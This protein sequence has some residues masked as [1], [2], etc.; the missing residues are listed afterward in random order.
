MSNPIDQRIVE[1]QFDNKEFEKNIKTTEES[2]EQF[3]K[4]LNLDEAAE[5]FNKIDKA[6]RSF[7][8]V[9]IGDQVGV[10]TSGFSS[11][12]NYVLGMFER[13]KRSA[14]DFAKNIADTIT[15][16]SIKAGFQ[17]YE[18]QIGAQ[19]T[20]LMG[21]MDSQ[22]GGD[23]QKAL[24]AVNASLNELNHYADQTI[25]N[26][27]Q[28][29]QAIGKF[30]A[31]GV[32]LDDA[33][34]S[35]KGIANLAA[36]AGA[37][38][39]QANSAM[40]M[41]SQSLAQGKVSLYQWRSLENS[42][43]ANESF[44]QALMRTADAMGVVG[45]EQQKAYAQLKKGDISFR[46]SIGKGWLSSDILIATLKQYAGE[47]GEAELAA[48]GF[49]S[50]E[51]AEILKMGK[52]AQEA[53]TKVKTFTQLIDVLKEALQSG[54]T[55]SW[56]IIFGD[57]DEAKEM[58][59]G[60][61][62]YLGN[63]INNMAEKRNA[64]LK[65]WKALGGKSDII[66][67]IKALGAAT[68]TVIKIFKEAFASVLP[69]S[70]SAKESG[71]ILKNV[72]V[73]FKL[74]GQSIQKWVYRN[75]ET[76]ALVFQT[77]VSIIKS[78]IGG[79]KNLISAVRPI[80]GAFG[81]LIGAVVNFISTLFKAR[82]ESKSVEKDAKDKK[83]LLLR[84][85]EWI[86]KVID[87]ITA[88][89]GK[90]KAAIIEF[91]L[92]EKFNAI[93]EKMSFW[94]GIVK[95]AI[96][97]VL[98]R[99]KTYIQESGILA[100]VNERLKKVFNVLGA[101]IRSVA[102]KIKQ[103]LL[104]AFSKTPT[105]EFK[106]FETVKTKLKTFYDN[107]ALWVNQSNSPIAG[108]VQ[109]LWG[110]AKQLWAALKA[111]FS[112]DTSGEKG[113]IAKLKKRFAAFKE[114]FAS[115]F[116]GGKLSISGIWERIKKF[117][118]GFFTESFPKFFE[119][120]GNKLKGLSTKLG[121][122]DLLKTVKIITK[123][124]KAYALLRAIGSLKGIIKGIR[125]LGKGLGQLGES[126]KSL[127]KNG[128]TI[129]H[130]KKD[131]LGTTIL[132]IA[133]AIGILVAALYV[134]T[135][136][137]RQDLNR[138]IIS[139]SIIIAALAILAKSAK[140][141]TAGAGRAL[142][143]AGAAVLLM[144]LAIKNLSGMD[145]D[146]LV[147]G[148]AAMGALLLELAVF[149]RIAGNNPI[150]G[151][152]FVG[153]AI[154]IMLMSKSVKSFS[155]MDLKGLVKGIGSLGA[156]LL[157]VAGFARLTSGMKIPGLLLMSVSLLVMGRAVRKLGEL[158]IKTLAKG[159][160]AVD[161]MLGGFSLIFLASKG[162]SFG[163]TV[164]MLVAMAGAMFVFVKAINSI[165]GVDMTGIVPFAE[166]FAVVILAIAGV[167][168]VLSLIN[169]GAC[170]MGLANLALIIVALGGLLVGL[171]ALNN[172]KFWK[173]RNLSDRLA[174]G[175]EVLATLAEVI[176]KI[177]GSFAGGAAGEML[178][179]IGTAISNF[180]V[181]MEPGMAV[182]GTLTENTLAGAGIFTAVGAAV[183]ATGF[184]GVLAEAL[185]AVFTWSSLPN[186]G[187][188]MSGFIE[189]IGSSKGMLESFSQDTVTGA[190]NLIAACGYLFGSSV[191]ASIASWVGGSVDL[192]DLTGEDGIIEQLGS[193]LWYFTQSISG[194]STNAAD[195]DAATLA[196]RG[197]SEILN[198]V[199]REGGLWQ[200]LAGSKSN[201]LEDFA[202]HH[203]PALGK[204]IRT[205]SEEIAGF[206]KGDDMAS[207]ND[208]EAAQSCA[209]GLIDLMNALPREGGIAQAILGHKD[210]AAFVKDLPN[211]AD[212]LKTYSKEIS[213]FSQKK[214]NKYGLATDSDIEA[215]A[216][217][218]KGLVDL[219]NKLPR[220]GGLLQDWIGE[221]DL[222]AFAKELPS[223]GKSLRTYSEE[224]S[225]FT[226]ETDEKDIKNAQACAEGLVSLQKALEPT[227]GIWQHF[228]G[229]VDLTGFADDV[230]AIGKALG[231]YSDEIGDKDFSTSGDAIA[232]LESLV[233]F[234]QKTNEDKG[235]A[236][237]IKE[238]FGG[239]SKLYKM[240]VD[241]GQFGEGFRK[242]NQGIA[243]AS[244]VKTRVDDVVEALNSFFAEMTNNFVLENFGTVQ[245]NLEDLGP[246]MSTFGDGFAAFNRA[247]SGAISVE[248]NARAVRNAVY[249]LID[250]ANYAKNKKFDSE[251]LENLA[252]SLKNTYVAD[253]IWAFS[254]GQEQVNDS[255]KGLALNAAN[256]AGEKEDDWRTIGG[257]LIIGLNNGL[258]DKE[259]MLYNTAR[260]IAN[261]ITNIFK[262]VWSIKS[263]SRVF[264]D[265]GMYIDQG[266]AIGISKY[267]TDVYRTVEDTADG[268]VRTAEKMLLSVSR[269]LSEGIDATPV[270]R[271]VL[272]LSEVESGASGISGLFETTPTVRTGLF[273]DAMFRRN[274]NMLAYEG[275]RPLGSNQNRDIITEIRGLSEKFEHLSNSVSNMQMVLDSGELIGRLGTKIDRNLGIIA[276][277]RERGN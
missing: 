193:S 6:A 244:I 129:T 69:F 233:A 180:I 109:K 92:F 223:I 188:Q 262:N 47:V 74:F 261:S 202:E 60:V 267:A 28:M 229:E 27:T 42:G 141:L 85:G 107:L 269:T 135:K 71:Q 156:I 68:E 258:V 29:T 272:D 70:G 172:A 206:A 266:L 173:E 241:I 199:P 213:G 264:Q 208:I 33:T 139:L 271:P 151:L 203:V 263:P 100:K 108:I 143:G 177:I 115:W 57:L 183:F 157:A 105:G 56:Q 255:A 201:S 5:S 15:V 36:Y 178:P 40:Y 1:M 234:A 152:S 98:N 166:G 119:G 16:D 144:S 248:T 87:K 73:A 77:I 195:I 17:E 112:V 52:D 214:K 186:V 67:G 277:R 217:C 192:S 158:D 61:S 147:K 24:D 76:I 136:I 268:T 96:A 197:L 159:I 167:I 161:L 221:K 23:R 205:Y 113:F 148:I 219:A 228:F 243:G 63:I 125:G 270:I 10:I 121:K 9:N 65:Y 170:L 273:S 110:L 19:Q 99:I 215:A 75:S 230:A 43:M 145:T 251:D 64:A 30:T 116:E 3:K 103:Y 120:I 260:T 44:R 106:L 198:S 89:I 78:L 118:S 127:G 114:V 181:A 80:A 220:A 194:L 252:I 131:A 150:K 90:V 81:R 31:Q 222:A 133:A 189:N 122:I 276:G 168:A 124:L 216:S 48:M 184:L 46:E 82:K 79:F 250:V 41:L 164:L 275:A 50:E 240:A 190:K 211:I 231:I 11:F 155:G 53:A 256:A 174:G 175:G 93:L 254:M 200:R 22:F 247:A 26:F 182:L 37:N 149:T 204:A 212:D 94:F 32:N 7:S 165:R 91:K 196:M 88:F 18:T 45:E 179:K 97:G 66:E 191:L 176:G 209:K 224:I 123:F 62:D 39:E 185:A 227:G 83:S 138:A 25:Y 169:I 58:W 8:L 13:L 238:Y 154:A 102:K 163:K 265:F 38:A 242:F 249:S 146:G 21:V 117:F 187:T 84:L 134:L 142:L 274:A 237:Q 72:S 104:N 126:L 14:L 51:R 128:Y 153:V 160:A 95:T 4:S 225:G 235:L 239:E 210:L 111:F 49:T 253:I 162:L 218:A 226:T 236:D 137:P 20:I 257:N 171:D 232:A 54:W 86:A 140:S 130:R 12:E 207:K 35:V 259:E 59:S 2:L 246:V 101:S 34:S 245:N 55:Q 132:K